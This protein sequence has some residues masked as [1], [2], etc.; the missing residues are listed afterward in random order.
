MISL[1]LGHLGISSSSDTRRTGSRLCVL[2]NVPSAAVSRED[3]W[4]AFRICGTLDFSLICILSKLTTILADN[5]IGV[6]A[7]STY[8]TD[9]ILVKSKDLEL[10]VKVLKD[11]GYVFR[12]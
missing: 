9:Y 6:F 1:M 7:I 3:G 5:G 12:Q 2:D 11:A 4:K 8:D 10:S